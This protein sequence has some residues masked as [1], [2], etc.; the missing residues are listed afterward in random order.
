MQIYLLL[1]KEEDYYNFDSFN[2]YHESIIGKCKPK[3]INRTKSHNETVRTL[4]LFLW[5][6]NSFFSIS[7][8][9]FTLEVLIICYFFFANSL[10]TL[11]FAQNVVTNFGIQ[12]NGKYIKFLTLSFINK[13]ER[14]RKRMNNHVEQHEVFNI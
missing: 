6:L 9:Q 5:T 4:T 3:K 10:Q 12:S 2:E 14:E 1:N 13:W 7:S 11:K 8:V